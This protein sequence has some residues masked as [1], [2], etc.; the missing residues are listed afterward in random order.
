MA[1]WTPKLEKLVEKLGDYNEAQMKSLL[2]PKVPAP[3]SALRIA[4]RAVTQGE[5]TMKKAFKEAGWEYQQNWMGNLQKLSDLADQNGSDAAAKI[6]KTLPLARKISKLYTKDSV[7]GILNQ[8]KA[9]K[10]LNI[11]F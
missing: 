2:N 4:F 5:P 6:K 10:K 7:S 3:A 1:K 9:A 8:V 11:K